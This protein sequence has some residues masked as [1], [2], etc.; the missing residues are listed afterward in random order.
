M[1][2]PRRT[3]TSVMAVAAIAPANMAAHETAL[4]VASARTVAPARGV[5]NAV[6]VM[7][8]SPNAR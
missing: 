2:L 5:L 3:S 8:C 6:V 7:G 1:P 4:L